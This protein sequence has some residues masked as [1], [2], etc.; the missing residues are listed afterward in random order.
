VAT[1]DI[2]QAAMTIGRPPETIEQW[3]LAGKVE[4]ERAGTDWV[5]DMRSLLNA[6]TAEDAA[7]G[8]NGG[9][10]DHAIRS[11]LQQP[12]DLGGRAAPSREATVSVAIAE[13]AHP[14]RAGPPGT[15]PP[16]DAD[17]ASP[18]AKTTADAASAGSPGETPADPG[19]AG[20][21]GAGAESRL[22]TRAEGEP[23]PSRPGEPTVEIASAAIAALNARLEQAMSEIDR[24]HDE[25]LKLALQLGYAQAQLRTY[26]EQLRAL[27]APPDP[28]PLT[29]FL[30][31]L[32]R[33]GRTDRDGTESQYPPSPSGRGLG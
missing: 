22:A 10:A 12:D 3:I 17:P 19:L 30:A 20:P 18:P 27:T 9:A 4:A 8:G 26:R 16:T 7:R 28:D 2:A 25:R 24:L 29:R 1:L 14:D 11:P 6:A 5:V 33:R 21:A 32:L 23:G 31:W 13:P 15:V